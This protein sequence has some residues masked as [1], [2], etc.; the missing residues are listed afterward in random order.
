ME[1]SEKVKNLSPAKRALLL[2]K[3][4]DEMARVKDAK[5]IPRRDSDGPCPLSYAQQG[6]W[7]LDQ[8]D[9][10]AF[11]LSIPIR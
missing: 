2:Q 4:R 7:F 5:R 11:P 8:L 6:L 3:M 10:E 1:L 9:R